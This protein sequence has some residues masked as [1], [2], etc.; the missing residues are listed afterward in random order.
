MKTVNRGNL[1]NLWPKDPSKQEEVQKIF[2]DY[3]KLDTQDLIINFELLE[4]TDENMDSFDNVVS[5]YREK[6]A[7]GSKSEIASRVY[8]DDNKFI[9]IYDIF[10]RKD[11]LDSGI[12][13]EWIDCRGNSS[14]VTPK[15]Q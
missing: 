13:E 2:R 5:V 15:N 9:Y 12:P 14:T 6:L 11:A 8:L 4:R 7:G 3:F 1:T 10:R